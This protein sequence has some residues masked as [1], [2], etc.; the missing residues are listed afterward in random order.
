M[1][2]CPVTHGLFFI[3]RWVGFISPPVAHGVFTV[4]TRARLLLAA[5]AYVGKQAGF[6]TWLTGLMESGNITRQ[7]AVSMLP[8][9]FLDVQPRHLVSCFPVLSGRLAF[10]S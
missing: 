5:G 10:V 3:E 7:E 8:P 1:N 4:C 2:P 6:H 9:L